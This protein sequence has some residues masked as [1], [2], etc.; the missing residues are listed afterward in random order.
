M[1]KPS[2]FNEVIPRLSCERTT[3]LE[4]SRIDGSFKYIDQE[5]GETELSKN[6][7]N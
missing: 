7:K 1:Y 3:D 5:S 4:I 6:Y 2:T